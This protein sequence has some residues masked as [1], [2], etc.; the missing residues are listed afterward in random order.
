MAGAAAQNLSESQYGMGSIQFRWNVS[1]TYMQVI[2][3]FISTDIDGHGNEKEFLNEWFA[4][5]GELCS[6]VFLKGYQW[7]FDS[8]KALGG[9]SL[10]DILVYIETVERGRRV[11]LDFCNNPDGFSFDSLSDEARTYLQRSDALLDTPLQRLRKMNPAAIELYRDHDI[12]LASEPLEIAVCAQHNNGGLAGTCWW[13]SINIKHLFPVGEVNG[14]HGVY[15]PGGSALNAGQVGGIRAAEYIANRYR[16]GQFDTDTFQRLASGA[17]TELN[18]WIGRCAEADT[19]WQTHRDLL[20]NRMSRAGAHIRSKRIVY[21]ELH[22]A[23][24]QWQLIQENGCGFTGATDVVEA[25]RTRQLCCAH[26]VYLD[27][28]RASLEDG[29]GSRGSAIVLDENG[30]SIHPALDER[31][32]VAPE[33]EEFREKILYSELTPS[34]ECVHRWI[35]RRPLPETDA[36]FETAWAEFRSGEIYTI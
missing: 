4:S 33:K 18:A 21:E 31:W 19:T 6:H 7:P 5:P 9:S 13:E 24:E 35:D 29:V 17:I 15:R 26:L 22:H 2:P 27:A 8:R 34:G 10:I 30:T 14:S 1:G 23:R 25:L 12:D 11:F 3:R 20:Q 16:E 32:R 28:I 36:W